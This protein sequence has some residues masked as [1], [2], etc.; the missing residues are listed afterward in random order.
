MGQMACYC[1]RMLSDLC[2]IP[3]GSQQMADKCDPESLP[4][5]SSREQFK[6]VSCQ[7]QS[8]WARGS[9]PVLYSPVLYIPCIRYRVHPL[10]WQLVKLVP[11]SL[12][13]VD[14]EFSR[15]FL[16]IMFKI[17]PKLLIMLSN[18]LRHWKYDKYRNN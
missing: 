8:S 7:A 9:I 13:N 2:S 12:F 6:V 4:A 10:D 15:E 16:A 11:S 5:S 14:I 1:A 3:L 17:T 18:D